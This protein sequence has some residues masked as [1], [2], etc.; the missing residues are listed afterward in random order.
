MNLKWVVIIFQT[1]MKWLLIYIFTDIFFLLSS[2]FFKVTNL[3]ST[4]HICGH[5]CLYTHYKLN[6]LTGIGSIPKQKLYSSTDL[7][8]FLLSVM[9]SVFASGKGALGWLKYLPAELFAFVFIFEFLFVFV[10]VLVF[11]L[12]LV[13]LFVFVSV[14]VFVFARGEGG[15]EWLANWKTSN[16]I[17]HKHWIFIMMQMSWNTAGEIIHPTTSDQ[18]LFCNSI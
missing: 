14:F 8:M 7:A 2:A 11:V 15:L 10:F 3:R 9:I 17:L 1:E 16:S 4:N 5:T 18:C 12:V 6:F 13:C